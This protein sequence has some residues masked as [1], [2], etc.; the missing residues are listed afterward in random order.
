M[1]HNKVSKSSAS[2]AQP[3]TSA[4]NNTSEDNAFNDLINEISKTV[5]K[6][7]VVIDKSKTDV[8]P[9]SEDQRDQR[10]KFPI[11]FSNYSMFK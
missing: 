3:R 7:N 11:I 4:S 10:L 8:G 6:K 5:N 1:K 9:A 2:N